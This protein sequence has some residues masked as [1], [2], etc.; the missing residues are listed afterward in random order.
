MAEDPMH[1][2]PEDPPLILRS[3]PYTFAELTQR[4]NAYILWAIFKDTR[5]LYSQSVA[6]GDPLPVSTLWYV[7]S[8]L[9]SGRLPL[10]QIDLPTKL[11][12]RRRAPVSD[13]SSRTQDKPHDLF[14]GA[15]PA[16]VPMTN[17]SVPDDISAITGPFMEK[18]PEY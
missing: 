7:T 4:Q 8:F 9:N 12:G 6:P 16:F 11:L 1:R 13:A 3:Q 17:D 10:D 2:H 14:P 18:F 5:W 15:K